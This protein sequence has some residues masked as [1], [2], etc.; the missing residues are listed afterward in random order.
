MSRSVITTTAAGYSYNEGVT[1]FLYPF[2]GRKTNCDSTT[3][4][5]G[6]N[7]QVLGSANSEWSRYS[8]TYR[9]QGTRIQRLIQLFRNPRVTR[10]S[11]NCH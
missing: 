1:S 3:R 2:S 8:P 5:D 9:L 11:L 10:A 7:I 6:S 4:S